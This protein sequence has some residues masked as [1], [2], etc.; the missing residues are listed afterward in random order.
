MPVGRE[1]PFTINLSPARSM[2][3]TSEGQQALDHFEA[4]Y[5]L[6]FVQRELFKIMLS[7]RRLR[8][9]ELINK[10]NLMREFY[11]RE[12]LVVR[13]QVHSSRKDRVDHNLVLKTKGP[14]RVL[15]KSTQISF[16]L[17]C[18]PFCE[19]LVR[20]EIKVQESK[21][22]MEKIPSAMVLHKHVDG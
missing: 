19:V 12:I 20:T 7:D 17:Q 1:F 11:A 21:A 13:K 16:L 15:E 3:V 6:M 2:E 18:L 14:Y 22:S 5:P 9:R 10:V 4:V 8:H